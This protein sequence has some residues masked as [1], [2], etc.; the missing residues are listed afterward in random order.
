MC[1]VVLTTVGMGTA[2]A[3]TSAQPPNPSQEIVLGQVVSRAKGLATTGREIALGSRACA[4]AV[5]AS[6][7]VRGRL[8]RLLS[9][10]DNGDPAMLLP[11]AKELLA[12]E[13]IVALLTPMG[14][15]GNGE[16]LPWAA[17]EGLAVVAPYGSGALATQAAA[18]S[19]TFFLRT[20]PSV[21][22]LRLTTQLQTL[23][24]TR[25]A[26]LYSDDELGRETLA[27][28]EEALASGGQAAVAL[29]PLRGEDAGAALK[30]L[31]EMTPSAAP[32]AVLL[33]TTGAQT[34]AV[35]QALQR[36]FQAG[37][38]IVPYALSS[39][40][41]QQDLQA[42]G[43]AARW[44]VL[45]Q[46]L[47]SPRAESLPLIKTYLAALRRAG[48]AAPSYPSLE[49]CVA[50]LT[51]VQALRR[52]NEPFTRAGVLKALR[53]AGVVDL[54]GWSVD[55]TDRQRPGSRFTDITLIGAD[56]SWV[57]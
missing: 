56:G 28:F 44:L 2:L 12:R 18:L 55:L 13:A 51:L 32:Q 16:V 19:S 31:A 15:S 1:G 49:G 29:L 27:A 40:V 52:S 3:Q 38:K 42:L 21:E 22:A 20:H 39:A 24:L 23:G 14:R 11:R 54:G 8:L 46:V 37:R 35:L 7:G 57:R 17:V 36:L 53:S 30:P 50:V 9:V 43:A 10:D 26:V 4:D 34:Q 6:G 47:P 48:Q 5:N 41:S 45:S 25:V 33:A